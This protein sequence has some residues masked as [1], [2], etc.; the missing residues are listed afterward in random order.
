VNDTPTHFFR[1]AAYKIE[2][3]EAE[4]IAV[5]HIA[6]VSPVGNSSGSM[7]A[8]HLGGMYDAIKMLHL[9][10]KIFLRFIEATESGEIPMDHDILRQLASLVQL[11]PCLNSPQF[12]ESFLREYNDTLLVTYLATITKGMNLINDVIDKFNLT[13]EKRRIRNIPGM[14]IYQ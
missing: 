6:H 14:A 8:S 13:Y 4:R 5:D 1:R 7:L 3:G 11:L 9:R 12:K 2:T 10:I